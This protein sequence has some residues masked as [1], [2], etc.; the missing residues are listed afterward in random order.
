[1]WEVLV[2]YFSATGN[3]KYVA[4]QLA[5]DEERLIFIPDAVD[6]GTFV[7]TV[8]SNEKLGII[9][10]TYNWTLPSIVE[11]FLKKMELRY[12]DRPYMY[13]VGTFGTTTGAAAT[14]A[15][16]ILKAKGLAFDAM[17]D[18]KMPDTWTPVFDL[19]EEERVS[20]MNQEADL[21]IKQLRANVRRKVKGKH[22]HLTTPY[23]T[24]VI[25]KAIYDKY[26][27]NTD[28][29]TVESSCIGCGLCAGKCP[30]HAIEIVNK[31]PVWVKEKCTMCLGCLHRCPVFAIQYGKNTKKHGQ[32]INPNVKV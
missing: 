29:F 6:Q 2:I 17:F 7:F 26:T 19:S 27:R 23:F 15:D 31:H 5:E 11:D 12:T 22:M 30:V 1:M 9:S 16:R 3:S 10:P 4:K 25:G 20:D 28:H 21:Q 18:V 13:Y 24:G 8:E 14:M 32:Y